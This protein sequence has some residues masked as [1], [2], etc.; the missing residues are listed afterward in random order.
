MTGLS[1]SLGLFVSSDD[2][3]FDD[4]D[5][6]LPMRLS[7]ENFD[8]AVFAGGDVLHGD[9]GFGD[10]NDGDGVLLEPTESSLSSA[11]S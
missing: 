5:E 3:L 4:D 8:D 1:L 7:I 9:D 10:G 2:D 6:V 11:E